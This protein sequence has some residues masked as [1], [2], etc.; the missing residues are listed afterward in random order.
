MLIDS[1]VSVCS[2]VV[3]L[4]CVQRKTIQDLKVSRDLDKKVITGK[5]VQKSG[6]RT[7][8]T[9]KKIT[10]FF[11]YLGVADETASIKVMVYGKEHYQEMKEGS[12]WM[13]RNVMMNENLMKVTKMSKIAKTRPVV[14]SE[15]LELEARMLIYP[16]RPVFSIEEAKTLEDKTMLSVE[17][18]I[19]QVSSIRLKKCVWGNVP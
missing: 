7:Y 11:F 4:L 9:K 5:V 6:L 12:N 19:T 10:R 18:T 2:D 8:Q 16:Q 1:D 17:G 15:E 13:F 3:Y 14:I